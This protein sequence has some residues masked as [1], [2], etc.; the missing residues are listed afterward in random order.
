[1]NQRPEQRHAKTDSPTVYLQ[2]LRKASSGSKCSL[3]SWS[4]MKQVNKDGRTRNYRSST[5]RAQAELGQEADLMQV[6][7]NQ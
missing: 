1:M 2:R 5:K 6:L 7:P 3:S 4:G